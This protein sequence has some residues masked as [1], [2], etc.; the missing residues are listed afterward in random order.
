MMPGHV[1][2]RAVTEFYLTV[3]AKALFEQSLG[4]PEL[5]N[6]FYRQGPFTLAFVADTMEKSIPWNFVAAFA[7]EMVSWTNRGY[8]GTY[9][10]GYWNEEG[11][12]RI[13][14]GLRLNDV[15][16]PF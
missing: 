8:L 4:K 6:I 10:N 3:L 13:F 9:D 16:L 5:S 7:H 1:A 2:A 12:L 11:T 15:I 14:A